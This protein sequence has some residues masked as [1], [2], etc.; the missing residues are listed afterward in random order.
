MNS[1][2][3]TIKDIQDMITCNHTGGGG[4][5]YIGEI[6]GFDGQWR[7]CPKCQQWQVV[8]SRTLNCSS[9]WKFTKA[10]I[11]NK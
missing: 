3:K 11:I 10:P 8:N 5:D 2:R 6:E 7:Y 4:F 9:K 1:A